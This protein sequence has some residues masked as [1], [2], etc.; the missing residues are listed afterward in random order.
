MRASSPAPRNP[1]LS[2][3][4]AAEWSVLRLLLANREREHVDTRARTRS[5]VLFGRPTEAAK[6]SFVHRHLAA[7]NLSAARPL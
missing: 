7:A 3:I 5:R 6:A 1:G 2:K 4:R